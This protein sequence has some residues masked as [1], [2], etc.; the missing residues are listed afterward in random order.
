MAG[1]TREDRSA[2]PVAGVVAGLTLV[3]PAVVAGQAGHKLLGVAGIDLI[4]EV[5]GLVSAKDGRRLPAMRDDHRVTLHLVVE[6]IGSSH[7]RTLTAG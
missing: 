5:A 1:A 7:A 4:E 2:T 3:A 6:P